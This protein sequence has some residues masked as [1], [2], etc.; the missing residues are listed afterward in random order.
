VRA[1]QEL[2]SLLDYLLHP[3]HTLLRLTV[4]AEIHASL[5]NKHIINFFGA[6]LEPPHVGLVMELAEFGSLYQLLHDADRSL[7]APGEYRHL[8]IDESCIAC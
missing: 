6:C 1:E 5:R 2:D 8:T 7:V 4:Q 3:T